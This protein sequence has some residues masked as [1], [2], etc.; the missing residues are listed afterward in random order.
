MRLNR[1]LFLGVLLT[2]LF[3]S[4]DKDD[5]RPRMEPERDRAEQDLEDQADLEAYL[6]THFYNYEDFE[7]PSSNFDYRIKIDSITDKNSDKIPLMDSDLLEE[8]SYTYEDI[9]YNYYVLKVREGAGLQPKSTDSAF[10]SYQGELL[11]GQEFDRANNPIWFDLDQV[12]PGFS[13]AIPQFKASTGYTVNPDNTVIWNQ[14]YGIGAVFLPSGLGYYS[15]PPGG[16][17]QYSPMVFSFHVMG[18]RETE[19]EEE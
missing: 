16:I 13:A 6:E 2:G 4:C 10:V 14:D 7:N 15:N 19:R 1:L 9:D 11:S 17:P 3:F 18:V 12:I 8:K 5:N